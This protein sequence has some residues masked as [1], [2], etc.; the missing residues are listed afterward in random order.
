MKTKI[1]EITEEQYKQVKEHHN[2]AGIFEEREVCGYGVY[3]DRYYEQ[4][5]KYYVSYMLGDSC[6]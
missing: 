2:A 1:K 5:G 4:D 6:D 3:G